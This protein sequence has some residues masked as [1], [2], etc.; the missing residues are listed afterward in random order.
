MKNSEDRLL[1]GGFTLDLRRR[2]LFR[3]DAR[4]HLT[5]KPL[6]TLIFLVEHRGQVVTKEAVMRSVWKDIAVTDGVLV[7]AVREIRR[8][9][10]DD[11]ENPSFVQTVPRE[12]YRFVGDVVVQEPPGATPIVHSPARDRTVPRSV[13]VGAIAV[14]VAIGLAMVGWRWA[15]SAGDGNTATAG[16]SPIAAHITPLTAGGISAVKPV[17]APDGKSLLYQSDTE[18]H[19]VLDF[20]LLPLN[21]GEPWRLTHGVNASGDIPVFTAD[22]RD[23]V[24]SR[25]RTGPDGSRVPDLWKVSAFGGTPVRYIPEASGA[26]FSPDDVW[27][28][29]TRYGAESRTLVVSPVSGLDERREVSTPG[30]TP[31]WSPDGKW[32]AYT[33]SYPEGGGGDVWIVSPSLA[34]RRRLTNQSEQMYG[35]SWSADSAS[36][37]FSGRVGNAFHL[38]RVSLTGGSIEPVTSGVGDYSSPAISMDGRLLAFTLYRPVRDLLY[39]QPHDAAASTLTSNESH[40]WPR[41]SPSGRRVAS[42]VLRSSTDE[43]LHVTNLDNAESR[44]VSDVPAAY[45]SWIDEEAVAYVAGSDGGT[46]IRR[47][48]LRSGENATLT[49]LARSISWLAMRPGGAEAAFVVADDDRQ[50]IVLRSLTSGR[51]SI[52]ASGVEIEQ[53]RWRADG[54]LLAWSGPR[55]SG[56]ATT[57][58]VHVVEPGRGTPRRAI[59]DGYAPAWGAGGAL[60][61]VRYVGDGDRAGI[62]HVDRTTGAEVQDRRVT[63]VDYFDVAGNVLVFA[64]DTARAQVFAMPLM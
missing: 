35:L 1:F 4:I 27:V 16:E 54:T 34:E 28:A 33:T 21:G 22:G 11:K 40:R 19:G 50:Q 6:E 24:F 23:V 7:Q 53:L 25:Y 49:R 37:V 2:A 17:F 42:V 47:V 61:F 39:A 51:E 46:E 13:Q 57:N 43:F 38:Q 10:G 55:V 41:L 45:P 32:L 3:G 12:G 30:F 14:A 48:D 31:R 44:R 62:W 60:F 15:A 59:A 58:G 9:L 20:F 5:P 64:R 18:R 36:I 26:G 29:Y 8:A 56:D 52:I 63:R